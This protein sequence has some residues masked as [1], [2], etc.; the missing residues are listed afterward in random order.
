MPRK[1]ISISKK[2][3]KKNAAVN[4]KIIWNIWNLCWNMKWSNHHTIGKKIYKTLPIYRKRKQSHCQEIIKIKH[5]EQSKTP[6]LKIRCNVLH[7]KLLLPKEL[8]RN[9][10]FFTSRTTNLTVVYFILKMQSM[11]FIKIRRR[12]F[13]RI[14][15]IWRRGLTK[16]SKYTK[17]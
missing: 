16:K 6:F 14:Y 15:F 8:I 5:S 12:F 4:K 11:W 13:S 1:N 10:R 9:D 7:W 3:W 17:C 2:K